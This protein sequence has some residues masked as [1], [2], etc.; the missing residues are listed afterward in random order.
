MLVYLKSRKGDINATGE[1]N[2]S[3]KEITVFKGAIV[4]NDIA[5]SEK[6]RGAKSI[7]KHRSGR[8]VDCVLQENIVLKSPSTA[9]NF[10]T[11]TSTNGLIAWKDKNG[12]TIK[13]ILGE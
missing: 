9:A 2:K 5:H 12:K 10:V 13:E 11:G 7:E 4:S 6:F 3:T 8:I 1:F